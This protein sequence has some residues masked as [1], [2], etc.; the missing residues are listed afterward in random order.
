MP[1][2]H[3]AIAL[4]LLLPATVM[5]CAAPRASRAPAPQ[6]IRLTITEAATDFVIRSRGNASTAGLSMPAAQLM[7]GSSVHLDRS[8]VTGSSSIIPQEI[9]NAPLD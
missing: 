4:A 2:R 3:K 8:L 7:L 9:S 5:G 1:N 6:M